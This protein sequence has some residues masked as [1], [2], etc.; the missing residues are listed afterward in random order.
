MIGP[1]PRGLWN[2]SLLKFAEPSANRLHRAVDLLQLLPSSGVPAASYKA[3][4]F[5]GF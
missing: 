4:S 1:F 2:E 5:D 3:V